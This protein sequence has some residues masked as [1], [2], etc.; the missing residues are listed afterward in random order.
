MLFMWKYFFHHQSLV[1]FLILKCRKLKHKYLKLQREK[2]FNALKDMFLCYKY[3][4]KRNIN[5][6]FLQ[7]FIHFL[8]CSYSHNILISCGHAS[9]HAFQA[10]YF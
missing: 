6:I 7:V 10:S 3:K 5:Y 1:M 2:T 9:M 4:K 8:K